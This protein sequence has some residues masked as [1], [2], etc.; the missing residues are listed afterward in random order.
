[1]LRRLIH[2]LMTFLVKLS[3]FH[4]WTFFTPLVK[5]GRIFQQLCLP[6]MKIQTVL[7]ILQA[8]EPLTFIFVSKC[9]W[10]YCHY[11]QKIMW[12]IELHFLV[13]CCSI[14]VYQSGSGDHM[15]KESIGNDIPINGKSTWVWVMLRCV[16]Y[17]GIYGSYS[18]PSWVPLFRSS[19]T[20]SPFG[21]I[22][23]SWIS[24]E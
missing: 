21:N 14:V 8:L 22:W 11:F 20:C 7:K 24:Q 5:L 3:N 18:P 16:A 10:Y 9:V 1:M 17:Y 4:F 2:A 13:R 19:K 12:V 6:T 15:E 23:T